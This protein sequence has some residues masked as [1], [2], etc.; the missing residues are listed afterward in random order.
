MSD[1]QASRRG[2]PRDSAVD[3]RVLDA[4]WELLHARGLAGLTVDEVAERAGAAK[5]TVYRRWPTKDHLMIALATRLLGEVPIA[6]TGDLRADLTSFAAALTGS[7]N[8]LRQAGNPHAG[9]SAGLAAELAASAARHP[10]IGE[11]VRCGFAAR[12]QLAR[13]RVRRA[14][15]NEA[16]RDDIDAE[17]LIDQVTGPIWYRVLVSGAPVSPSYAERLV[18]AALDGAFRTKE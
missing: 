7:L 1:H 3:S 16:L 14:Q 4:A 8:R 5:T 12:H 11:M 2:R 18:T 17:I 9:A 13:A 10:D 6:D 15:Q